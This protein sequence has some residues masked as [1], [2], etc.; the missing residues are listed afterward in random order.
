MQNRLD[1]ISPVHFKFL[2]VILSIMKESNK[3]STS[4]L[5]VFKLRSCSWLTRSM[6]CFGTEV[7]AGRQSRSSSRSTGRRYR[8]KRRWSS[9][10]RSVSVY[11]HQISR[12]LHC[13]SAQDLNR[14]F[15]PSS[16]SCSTSWR[17]RSQRWRETRRR[18]RGEKS[19]S[20]GETWRE[21]LIWSLRL[22]WVERKTPSRGYRN[23]RRYWVSLLPAKYKTQNH[24]WIFNVSFDPD[25][26]KG[27]LCSK[28]S[29]TERNRICA[30]PR[31]GA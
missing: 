7:T 30:E 6:K 15:A 10:L 1:F 29:L 25:R 28:T 23:N 18:P 17:W 14:A 8:S 20:C 4:S 22:W 16:R 3:M 19:W 2:S 21:R 5:T 24:S 12:S 13:N 9:K 11:F 31:D 26:G 27:D